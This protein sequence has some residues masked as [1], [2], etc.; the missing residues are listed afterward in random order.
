DHLEAVRLYDLAVAITPGNAEAEA[1]LERARNL[2]AVMDLTEQGSQHEKDLELEAARLSFA[3][4][5]ELD[6]AFAPA[7]NG[8][9]RVRIAIRDLA[10]NRHMTEGFDALAAGHY[11]SARAAFNAAGALQPDSGQPLD[12]LQQVDLEE[13]LANIRRLEEVAGRL[14][15]D[16]QW[17]AAVSTYEE[18]LEIDGDLQFAKEGLSR[19]TRRV[20]L[21]RTL[22]GYI[23]NPDSLSSDVNMQNATRLLLDISR[24]SPVGPRLEDQKAELSRLL[25]RA[26][27]PLDVQ[28]VSDNMTNVSVYKVGRFG[29]FAMQEL[30]L[31]P[32]TYVAV[33]SRPGFRDVRLEFRVAPEI[34]MK[35]IVIQCEERI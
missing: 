13:R 24:M 1:G 34:E 8:L 22:E 31:R 28:L 5:I 17:D 20:A 26:A 10:F 14:E 18:L 35:P 23:E 33:G 15:R 30:S 27:T 12:G 2:E 3:K 11:A 9:E 25:K 7:M 32:G 19:S 21:H 29:T 6:P 4:A 16:E